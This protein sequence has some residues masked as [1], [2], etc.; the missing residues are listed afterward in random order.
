MGAGS[1]LALDQFYPHHFCF[2]VSFTFGSFI[3]TVLLKLIMD[4][5]NVIEGLFPIEVKVTFDWHTKGI[6]LVGQ[7]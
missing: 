5:M 3:A 7:S 4:E 1:I 6:G 2:T